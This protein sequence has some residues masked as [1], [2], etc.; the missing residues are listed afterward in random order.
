MTGDDPHQRR[1]R[2]DEALVVAD[3]WLVSRRASIPQIP[4]YVHSDDEVR[5]WFQ[6]VVIPSQDVWVTEMG[7]QLV[8]LM[9]LGDKWIEQLYVHPAWSNRGLGTDL[10]QIAKRGCPSLD[11]WTFQSNA[12]A[13]RFYERNGFV[14]VAMTDGDNEEGAPDIRYHWQRA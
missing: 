10:L 7:E 6:Q 1:A 2:P 12:G 3:L 11:L 9:A 14:S 13:M 5:A 4:P 8:A